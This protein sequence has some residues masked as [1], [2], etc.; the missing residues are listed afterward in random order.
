MAEGRKV[1][2]NDTDHSYYWVALKQ[3]GPA[4]HPVWVWKNFLAGNNTAFMDPYLVVWPERN[5]PN[6][7]APDP[8]WEPLRQALGHT[9]LYAEKM[10]LAAMTPHG[11]LSSTG[12]CLAHPGSEYLIFQPSSGPF[13]V[14]LQPGTYAVEWFDPAAGTA[15]T[16]GT[17]RASGKTDF[18]PPFAGAAVLHLRREE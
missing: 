10:D 1:I 3:D 13:A 7:T 4:A 14:H 12:Y 9:R 17:M 18:S 2:I 16:S 11:D 15:S 6:G 5:A 8:Y